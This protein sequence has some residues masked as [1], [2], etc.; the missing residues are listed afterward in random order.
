MKCTTF[1]YAPF[2]FKRNRPMSQFMKSTFALSMLFFSSCSLQNQKDEVVRTQYYH[3]YGPEINHKTWD[4]QGMTGNMVQYY[5]SGI[6]V[7]KSYE[8]GVLHGSSTWTY[9]NSSIVHRYEEYD[10]GVLTSFGVNYENGTSE[11]QEEIGPNK[12]RYVRAWYEDGSPKFIEEWDPEHKTLIYAHY[13]NED[14]ELESEIQNGNGIRIERAR[15]RMLLSREQY[16]EGKVILKEE[17]FPNGSIKSTTSIKDEKKNGIVY[18]YAETGQP[19]SLEQW[20]NDTID[21]M[22]TYFDHGLKSSQVPYKN[23]IREGVETRYKPGT[24]QIVATITWYNNMRHGPSTFIFPDQ[25]ITEWYWKDGK[26]TEE[27][28]K[29][30]QK[31]TELAKQR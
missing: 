22:Q 20:T 17:F 25:E 11:L 3:V 29:I 18:T 14:G 16:L 30:R 4:D 2:N 12:I 19:I 31:Q 28:Y 1:E 24:D 10:Q 27:M 5:K 15:N 9:P 7:R 26:V 23:G 8:N 6:R 13:F 21:G